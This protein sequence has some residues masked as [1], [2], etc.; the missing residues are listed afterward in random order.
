MSIGFADMKAIVQTLDK[1]Q[2][3][4]FSSLTVTGNTTL[5]NLSTTGNTTLSNLTTTGLSTLRTLNVQ[6]NIDVIGNIN[7]TGS[8]IQSG[9]PFTIMSQTGYVNTSDA[10][11]GPDI[12]F[13]FPPGISAPDF[14][15]SYLGFELTAPGGLYTV[16]FGIIDTSTSLGNETVQWKL[17][18]SRLLRKNIQIRD[19]T[20]LGSELRNLFLRK[21]D[22]VMPL[23]GPTMTPTLGSSIFVIHKVSE[24]LPIPFPKANGQADNVS[25]T[26]STIGDVTF[27][28]SPYFV[29]PANDGPMTYIIDYNDVDN[30]TIN[31]SIL[32]I[33]GQKR[34]TSY[35]IYIACS[36]SYGPSTG[37]IWV[38]VIET[39]SEPVVEDVG[40]ITQVAN[41]SYDYDVQYLFTNPLYTAMTYSIVS[42]PN[43]NAS[44]VGSTLSVQGNFRGTNYTIGVQADNGSG[45]AQTDVSVYELGTLQPFVLN[46]STIPLNLA[47]GSNV[48]R[49]GD[50][51]P[52]N[53]GFSGAYPTYLSGSSAVRFRRGADTNTYE[54]PSPDFLA[55]YDPRSFGINLANGFTVSIKNSMD[56]PEFLSETFFSIQMQSDFLPRGI[57][58][59]RNSFTPTQVTF[60]MYCGPFAFSSENVFTSI[61]ATGITTGTVYVWFMV[62][63]A[64]TIKIYRNNTLVGTA[65][66]PGLAAF[67]MQAFDSVS[68]SWTQGDRAS[69][70]AANQTVYDFRYYNTALNT[71]ALTT[72]YNS[73][74]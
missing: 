6:S 52:Q 38:H 34:G 14:T 45:T 68:L 74:A 42:N 62:Y 11:V 23:N 36:N 54:D 57:Q 20:M 8:L 2:L 51:L 21:G 4:T 33:N 15:R 46:A 9:T 63:D 10:G 64:G 48:T 31:G 12:G 37:T 39:G 55:F 65:N 29:N 71:T 41:S 1:R 26:I 72:L 61:T 5:S 22:I 56:A 35:D 59:V 19:Y 60:Q 44:I 70:P 13:Y 16:G 58:M 30:A 18:V 50:F 17:R 49:W 7:F 3:S 69:N 47:S 24:I 27:D 43:S 66:E 53:Y 32:T 73:I 67:G 28:V 25:I 40:I